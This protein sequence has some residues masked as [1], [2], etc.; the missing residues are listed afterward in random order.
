MYKFYTKIHSINCSRPSVVLYDVQP[1]SGVWENAS[2]L[3]STCIH[4]Q[5]HPP[6]FEQH[7]RNKW[8]NLATINTNCSLPRILW[9]RREKGSKIT[10]IALL[11]DGLAPYTRFPS[12]QL[13]TEKRREKSVFVLLWQRWPKN[14]DFAVTIYTFPDVISLVFQM[15][16]HISQY[17]RPDQP[18]KL[19]EALYYFWPPF[20]IREIST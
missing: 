2:V 16:R 5:T 20:F 15:I 18:L 4:I 8:S 6:V 12:K 17:A 1:F 3:F 14:T 10:L 7:R 19:E 13:A 11:L 9:L